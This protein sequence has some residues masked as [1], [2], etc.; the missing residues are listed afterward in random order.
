MGLRDIL[1]GRAKLK[2]PAGDRLFALTT[3]A[4]T[5]DVECGLKPA[6]AGAVV[7]KPLS[8]GEFAQ[9]DQDVEQLLA[10]VASGFG[11]KLERKKD[12]YG[13]DWVVI[14]D[15]ELEDQVASVHAVSSELT[16]RGFGGQL[17]AAAF[18]FEGGEHPVYWI[19][20]FKTGT[21]WPFVP[22]GEKQQRDN[23]RELELKAK[24]EKELPVEQDI[25]RWLA[26]FDAPI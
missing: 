21:F 14:R 11:S 16:A 23:P 20:G 17:L 3:A 8:A 22:T 18:R 24:L 4:V 13:F 26:L 25:S 9:A 2:E 6:G 10:S 12:A 15:P 7:Y 1:S 19:Y 5:L